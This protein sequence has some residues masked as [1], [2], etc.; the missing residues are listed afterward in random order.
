MIPIRTLSR[1][2]IARNFSSTNSIWAAQGGAGRGAGGGDAGA[3]AKA[4]NQAKSNKSP[5]RR[6]DGPDAS[7]GGA[8]ATSKDSKQT[9]A[10]Q[11]GAVS[12]RRK[13]ARQ[14]REQ[15]TNAH[16]NA[17]SNSKSGAKTDKSAV[18]ENPTPKPKVKRAAESAA[19]APKEPARTAKANATPL[20]PVE[21]PTTLALSSF[22]SLFRE[23]RFAAVDASLATRQVFGIPAPAADAEDAEWEEFDKRRERGA[24]GFKED[25]G[26]YVPTK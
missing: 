17:D 4:S 8:S 7:D 21:G 18:K 19:G 1:G 5:Y 3:G 13:K 15:G 24:F 9:G 16:A 22:D 2:A 20:Q 12:N 10:G 26:A 25:F 23:S 14:A 11:D 6:E